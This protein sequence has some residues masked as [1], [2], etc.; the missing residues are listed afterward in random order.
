M[1]VNIAVLYLDPP[2]YEKKFATEEK[3]DNNY[4][5]IKEFI[6]LLHSVPYM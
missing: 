4:L 1:A 3:C 5:M 6:L 2:V